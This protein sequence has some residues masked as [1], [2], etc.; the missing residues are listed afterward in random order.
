M[1]RV[2]ESALHILLMDLRREKRTDRIWQRLVAGMVQEIR[3]AQQAIE[4][5]RLRGRSNMEAPHQVK[6]KTLVERIP[7]VTSE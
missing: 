2:G 7:Q 3:Q 4:V 6:R 1:G 5:A